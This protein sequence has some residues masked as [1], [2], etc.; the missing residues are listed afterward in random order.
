MDGDKVEM[1]GIINVLHE[2]EEGFHEF[3][4]PQIPGFYLVVDQD[5]LKAG[6]EDIP[7]RRKIR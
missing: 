7:V 5:D 4:S 6:F 3:T 2:C 1:S